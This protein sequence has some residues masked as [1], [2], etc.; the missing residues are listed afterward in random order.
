MNL[1]K[2]KSIRDQA[3]ERRIS[4]R[5]NNGK[6]SR[7]SDERREKT[8]EIAALKI[9]YNLVRRKKTTTLISCALRAAI[10]HLN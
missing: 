4:Q 3:R 7:S 8:N 5:N 9:S 6:V 1:F 2:I 10:K